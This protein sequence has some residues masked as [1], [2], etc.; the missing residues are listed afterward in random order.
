[1]YKILTQMLALVGAAIFAEA[2]FSQIAIAQTLGKSDD[3]AIIFNTGSTNFPGYRINLS[4][5]GQLDYTYFG[6]LRNFSG[7]PSG[8]STISTAVVDDF[9]HDLEADIPLW[10]PPDQFCVK[11][12]SFGSSTFVQFKGQQSQNLSCPSDRVQ[13]QAL[14][15]DVTKIVNTKFVSSVPEPSSV[16]GMLAFGALGAATVLKRH[17]KSIFPFWHSPAKFGDWNDNIAE[18]QK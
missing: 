1:M 8:S 9:Y 11:S 13:T 15:A 14:A 2:G 10:I 4:P 16:L 3:T 18:S 17:Q 6:N 7:T 5:S 12:V